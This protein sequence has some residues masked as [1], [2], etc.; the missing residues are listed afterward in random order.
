MKNP[1]QPNNTAEVSTVSS[2]S[3][4]AQR[5]SQQV[6]S[7]SHGTTSKSKVAPEKIAPQCNVSPDSALRATAVA[8]GARIVSVSDSVS[9]RNAAQGRVAAHIMPN[10]S[11]SMRPLIPAGS[12]TL[13]KARSN[14]PDVT[15]APVSSCSAVAVSPARSSTNTVKAI[16]PAVDNHL[17]TV[18]SNKSSEQN[19]GSSVTNVVSVKEEANPIEELKVSDPNL[20]PKERVQEDGSSV[21]KKTPSE[22]FQE[23]KAVPQNSVQDENHGSVVKNSNDVSNMETT[24][25]HQIAVGNSLDKD[26]QDSTHNKTVDLPVNREGKHHSADNGSSEGQSNSVQDESSKNLELPS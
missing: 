14:V 1:V 5:P 23:D 16:S 25:N 19:N 7:G 8:A 18:S 11:S 17:P 13:L 9:L 21:M 10:V 3:V 24:G 2:N 12:P 6:L 22:E 20:V 15:P 4:Q 26:V